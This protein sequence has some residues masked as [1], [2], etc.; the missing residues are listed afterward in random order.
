MFT[1]DEIGTDPALEEHRKNLKAGAA[2]D[3]IRK[4]AQ[5][6]VW[7]FVTYIAAQGKK[8][9]DHQHVAPKEYQGVGRWWGIRGMSVGWMPIVVMGRALS[10]TEFKKAKMIIEA[11]LRQQ[12]LRRRSNQT[13]GCVYYFQEY[14]S[15]KQK[16][17]LTNG[18]K[19]SILGVGA[20]NIELAVLSKKAQGSDQLITRSR[21]I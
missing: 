6:L 10:I 13:F 20:E 11:K 14:N 16:Y 21:D 2:V 19:D 1:S 4:T 5:S 15:D 7:Y 9:K 8:S 17:S 12:G 3:T 18:I